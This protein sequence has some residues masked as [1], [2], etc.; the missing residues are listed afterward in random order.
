MPDTNW[1]LISGST[2]QDYID[3]AVFE[4]NPDTKKIAL[5][6]GQP[7]VAGEEN[8]QYISF[9]M[10]RY[11]DGIDISDKDFTIEYAL[12]GTYYGTSEAVNAEMT[13]E[14]VRFGWIVPKEACCISG[15][16][17]FV[18]RIEST[19]YV[20]KTQIAEHPVFKSVNVEDVVP[21]PTKEAWYR[22]FANRVE[23]AIAQA[24]DALEQAQAAVT[25]A[26]NAAQNAQ[27]SENNAEA[28][29]AEA[30]I[31]YGSPLTASE[32][33]MMVEENRVYVYTGSESGYT[34]G[35]WYYYDGSAWVSG[36][37]YNGSGV[38]TDTTLTQ[39]GMPADAKATGD[40][41]SQIKED[42]LD[43]EQ[44]GYPMASIQVAVN[45]WA[46]EHEDEIVNGY[47]TP[48]MYGAKGDGTT[49]DT[50]AI[51]SAVSSGKNVKF[52]KK[53]YVCGTINVNVS[54]VVIDGDGATL[55]H[56]G[57]SGF[58]V[59][60]TSHDITFRNI[61]S[62]CTYVKDSQATTN[63]HI[64]INAN[65]ESP[66]D[67]FYAHDITI[68]N[69]TF[70]GG[71]MG[72]SASSAKDVDIENCEFNDFV[73]KP[74][75]RAGG[76]G[77]LLQSCINSEISF[78]NFNLGAYG[79]HDIYV[80]VD[81]RK[82]TNKQSKNVN[83]RS[84]TF[85]HSDLVTDGSGYYYSPNTTPINVRTSILVNITD[86]YFYSTVGLASLYSEDE[87]V[88]DSNI[89]NCVVDTPVVNTGS[90]ELKYV[91]NLPPTNYYVTTRI[92][93]V[94]V[95][96]APSAYN[97]FASLA[98]C[99]AKIINCDIGATRIL[100]GNG[101]TVQ[102]NNITTNITYYFI[103]FNGSDETKGYCRNITFLTALVGE[104]YYFASGSS[105]PSDFFGEPTDNITLNIEQNRITDLVNNSYRHGKIA[106]LSGYFKAASGIS[107][108]TIFARLANYKAV[109][110]TE[111]MI[112]IGNTVY[113]MY[114]ENGN[115]IVANTAVPASGGFVFFKCTCILQ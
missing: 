70:S 53:T 28:A 34:F 16:L 84:C 89:S 83:I 55:N 114:I 42:L 95:I 105:V 98:N 27:A 32:A 39:S 26:E 66:S 17:L 52:G 2:P 67:E 115:L 71:V 12:A 23:G 38:N 104:K 15:T 44:E 3:T 107:T 65:A 5:I 80:S 24:E 72:V 46:T 90:D 60:H 76:Y 58:V 14:Q 30:Q 86:C 40:E 25:N 88:T 101:V 78:C 10:P 19:D 49:D 94:G 99:N 37:V 100:C 68:E 112:W 43:L 102:L 45:A 69:C 31:R 97:S 81:Q 75:D 92:E 59:A 29:A 18:L 111:G 108:T 96:N 41:I 6:T 4:V 109:A 56:G 85:D 36:G 22:D 8:S 48:E 47:V 110:R 73:F 21:E 82:T 50:S 63:V 62:I 51:Q 103:R 33:A 1:T 11:W 87:I 93:G 106:V 113:P 61:K 13:T 91:I 74:E 54:D 35:N 9:L 64:G 79:R 7:L 20:L 77:I 57:N